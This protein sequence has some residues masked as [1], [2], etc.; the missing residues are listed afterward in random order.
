MVH[1]RLPTTPTC[2]EIP[3]KGRITKVHTGNEGAVR[4]VELALP[5]K[6]T[7]RR[8]INLLISL[9]LNGQ[10][11]EIN[12]ITGI[13]SPSSTSGNTDTS[14]EG[15]PESTTNGRVSDLQEIAPWK[16]TSRTASERDNL[17]RRQRLNYDPLHNGPLLTIIYVLGLVGFRNPWNDLST[18]EDR[19]RRI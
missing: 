15:Y 1:R 7:T 11:T 16:G 4:D 6:R 13:L 18:N 2:P 19:D 17:R 5:N 3:G 12:S 14:S 10:E 8:P 9:E